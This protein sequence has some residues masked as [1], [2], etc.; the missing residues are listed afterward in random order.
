MCARLP[1]GV[2]ERRYKINLICLPLREL[3]VILWMDWLSTNRILIDCRE[4]RLLFP[5]SEEF[6]LLSP[7]GV[8]IEIQ[9]GAQ[10]FIIFARMEAGERDRQSYLWY[11][12]LK[13]CFR[14]KY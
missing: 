2:E 3:E 13:S 10:C 1:V 8:A 5:D 4:K 11:M 14:M 7:Q 9:S 12:S 6:Q